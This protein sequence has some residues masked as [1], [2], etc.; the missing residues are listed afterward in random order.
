MEGDEENRWANDGEEPTAFFSDEDPLSA[1][2]A[3]S[4]SDGL[5]KLSSPSNGTIPKARLTEQLDSL[6]DRAGLYS[7][8]LSDQIQ[9]LEG[10]VEGTNLESQGGDVGVEAGG[11]APGSSLK[12]KRKRGGGQK[13]GSKAKKSKPSGEE[14]KQVLLPLFEGQLR[15]YQL[16]G[17][18]WL[19]SLYQNGIN[20]I[21]ADEMGLGKTIQTIAF[22][23]HLRNNGVMGPFLIV[24]P[25]STL[26]NWMSEFECFAPSIPALMYHGSKQER[27]QL[28]KLKIPAG[29]QASP[30]FP[31]VITSYEILI[32]DA[33]HFH[34]HRFKYVVVDEGHRLKNFDCL[35]VRQLKMVHTDS[36]LLL[37]GTPLQNNLSE[38]WSLLNFLMPDM[39]PSL[40][41]FKNLF[42][43]QNVGQKGAC[44][45]I[46]EAER[47]Q[48]IVTKLHNILL[49][50]LLRRMK[51]DVELAL[52]QKT[53]VV[54]YAPMTSYQKELNKQLLDD[55]VSFQAVS[56]NGSERELRLSSLNN[57]LMQMRKICNHPDLIL[58]EIDGSIKFPSPEQL[59]EQCGKLALMDRILKKLH[60]KGHKVLIFSQMTKMLDLLDSFFD[61]QGHEALRIDGSVPWQ[62]RQERIN[63]FNTDPDKWLFLLSTRAGGLGINLTAADTVI[64]YDS[65]W[66]PQQDLQAMDRCHRIG[67]SKPVL[68]LRLATSHSVEGKMLR[69]ASNKMALTRL[70]IK[71]GA[72]RGDKET[73]STRSSL[74]SDE[75]LQLLKAD[76]SLDDVPQSG[77][78]SD[79]IMDQ[80]LDRTDDVTHARIPAAG[81]GYEIVQ[82]QGCTDVLSTVTRDEPYKQ[83]DE[84]YEHIVQATPPRKRWR[85]PRRRVLSPRRDN[86]V[87]DIGN[88]QSVSPGRMG[89]RS[90]GFGRRGLGSGALVG[91]SSCRVR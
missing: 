53:E 35:L 55:S 67:Q 59:I 40:D 82:Q 4:Q 62:E 71:K 36:R 74:A 18:M 83:V 49:P 43:F 5:V 25:L 37:T 44:Q 65:D 47:E 70:V 72:F 46:I 54:L 6:L 87:G 63:T 48:S 85:S 21:L 61:E 27:E 23:S 30:D 86:G 57:V 19:I 20:G 60:S 24:A 66:N 1:V 78:V 81:V 13:G 50:F 88:G 80:L 56:K 29:V 38:L 76:I 3:R 75:L 10:A 89:T 58:G 31:V 51:S 7:Q 22:L 11:D 79:D 26:A 39:F 16:T 90:Q 52:P 84:P 17:V 32:R 77:E 41:T 34:H 69:R 91:S 68:V 14:K 28:R 12:G 9:Q 42:D 64:I 15:D 2:K 45:A 33:P 8:F 73:K